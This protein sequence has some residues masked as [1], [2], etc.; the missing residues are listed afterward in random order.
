[1]G[2]SLGI[3]ACSSRWSP[4]FWQATIS[5]NYFLSDPFSN[6]TYCILPRW[7]FILREGLQVNLPPGESGWLF[8]SDFGLAARQI[9]SRLKLVPSGPNCLSQD[10]AW[11]GKQV[12]NIGCLEPNMKQTSQDHQRRARN[13]KVREQQIHDLSPTI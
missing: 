3:H 6:F 11:W 4:S 1:M 9:L 2:G 8:P 13:K 7:F 5:L 12:W 10:I